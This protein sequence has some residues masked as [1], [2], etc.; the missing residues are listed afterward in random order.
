MKCSPRA[1][2]FGVLLMFSGLIGCGDSGPPRVVPDLPDANAAGKAMELYDTNHDGFLD[3]KELDQAPG[4][5]AALKQIDTNHAHKISEQQIADRIKNWADSGVGRMQVGCRVTHDGK[6]LVGA[7]V[8]FAPEKFLGGTIQSGSG[9]TSAR[10]MAEVSYPYPAD[11]SIKG[12][13]PGFYRVEITK[14]G[15]KIPAEYNTETTLGAEVASG[16]D[17]QEHGLKFDLHY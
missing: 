12:M 6:P 10:G 11:P 8:V 5:K 9:T 4:L 1:C 15:E 13:P 17:A 2:V 3:E 14:E 7:K 16:S